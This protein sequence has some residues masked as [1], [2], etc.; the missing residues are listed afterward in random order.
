MR[1]KYTI[2]CSIAAALSRVISKF[3]VEYITWYAKLRFQTSLRLSVNGVIFL[4]T[5]TEYKY[6]GCARLDNF[7][8]FED[9]AS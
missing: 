3:L 8:A 9:I 5:I 7:D 2:A 1:H 6:F 4:Y